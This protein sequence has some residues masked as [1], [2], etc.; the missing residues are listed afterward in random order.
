MVS[1]ADPEI[2]EG[3]AYM[4]SGDWC[5]ARSTQLSVHAHAYSSLVPRAFV[6]YS[7]K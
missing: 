4:K 1:G 2:E 6:A 3:G 7:T 5:G